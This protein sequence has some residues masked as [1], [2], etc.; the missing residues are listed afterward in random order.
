MPVPLLAIAVLCVSACTDARPAESAGVPP[1]DSVA[2]APSDPTLRSAVEFINAG[3][4]YS[5]TRLLVPVLADSA[6]RTPGALYVAAAAAAAWGGW[7]EVERLVGAV[8]WADSL[9]GGA[10]RVLATRAA[11]GQRRDSLAL[12]RARLAVATAPN[13]AERGRRLVYLGRAF[14]RLET[15]DSAE[16]AYARAADL[17]PSIADWLRLRAAGVTA[18]STR[19]AGFFASVASPVARARIPWTDATARE[20]SGDPAG[21]A[22]DYAALGALPTAFRLRLLAASA[23]SAARA[24][25]RTEL[26]SFVRS[27][28]G[29]ADARAAVEVLDQ[30]F[31]TLTPAEELQVAR[32]AGRAGPVARA[33]AGFQRAS[34][35]GVALSDSDRFA[36]AAALDRAGQEREAAAAYARVRGP[37]PLAAAAAYGR[38]RALLQAGDRA[39]SMR[40]LREVATRFPR[41]TA[42]ANALSLLADLNTDDAHD[43][44]ARALYLR[45]AREFPSTRMAG[46]ARFRAAMIA[47]AAGSAR[48]AAQELDT[49]RARNAESEEVLAAGYWAGRAWAQAGDSAKA[50]DR[51]RAVSTAEPLSYYASAS[52]RRLGEKAWSPPQAAAPIA[53]LP[54][55]DSAMA[56]AALLEG[57]GLDLEARFEYDKLA[58]DATADTSRA[59]PTAQAFLAAGQPSRAIALAWQAIGK[60][61]SRDA[62]A[63]R[64]AYPVLERELIARESKARG[65][66]PAFVAAVIRQESSFNPGATS[67]AGARGLMQVMPSVG[68]SMARA[69]GF[70]PWDAVLLYQPDV[71]VELGTAHLAGFLKQ[72]G[73]PERALAA[74]NAGNSRVAAWSKKPGTDDPELF[75]ERIPFVETRDYVRI[76]SR[77]RE[78][79]R[80]LY[81]W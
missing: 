19:R 37:V 51:W 52:A 1:A 71:S 40:A 72:F 80:D 56:R 79:Y 60:G 9:F 45:V 31:P 58:R 78:M 50:R 81:D 7:S 61:L 77:N 18:D 46:R 38:G 74:Y 6:R 53:H 42:A 29:S 13:D 59:L 27:R 17:V 16:Y 20:R 4:P 3:H 64:L 69:R 43:P 54:A 67:P 73:A 28:A 41:D 15:R 25:V 44:E 5:A 10:A 62:N 2:F 8:P 14:D 12:Q 30:A 11:L 26:V 76:V 49:L 65:V 32:S 24:A 39:A 34:S 70:A 57:L 68:A 63:Y 55:V 23:D 21:A 36:W 48:V 22:R 35:G 75:V 33:L 66:D 47:L